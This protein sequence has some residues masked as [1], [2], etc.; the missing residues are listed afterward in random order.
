M[1]IPLTLLIYDIS[2]LGTYI[3]YRENGITQRI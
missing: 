1:I 3:I 2:I